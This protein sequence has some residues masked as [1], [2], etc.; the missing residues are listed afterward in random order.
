MED[1][2]QNKESPN[3]VVYFEKQSCCSHSV[4][5]LFKIENILLL[6]ENR[7]MGPNNLNAVSMIEAG[8]Y[9]SKTINNPH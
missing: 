6:H 4:Q 5:L 2:A 9:S 1:Q 3:Y 8:T 7:R